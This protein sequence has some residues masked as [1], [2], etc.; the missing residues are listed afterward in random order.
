M[1]LLLHFK[2]QPLFIT[3]LIIWIFSLL[4]S[5]PAYA[6]DKQAERKVSDAVNAGLLHLLSLADPDKKVIFDP[7]MLEGPSG[8]QTIIKDLGE[9]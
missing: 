9:T 1:K 7:R 3:A 8:Q 4:I 5:G 2:R 6:V